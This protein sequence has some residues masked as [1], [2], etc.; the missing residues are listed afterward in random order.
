MKKLEPLMKKA[1]P[2]K[3]YAIELETS[4]TKVD[5][6]SIVPS[7]KQSVITTMKNAVQEMH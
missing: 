6:D 2:L 4:I 7:E 5:G 1:N 3:S